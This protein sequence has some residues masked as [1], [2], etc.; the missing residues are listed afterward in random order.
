MKKIIKIN[1]KFK[2]Y[3]LIVEKNSAIK[4][5]I[6]EVEKNNK[7]IIII[8]S[9]LTN[10]IQKLKSINN[11]NLIVISASE[12][13]KSFE[14]YSK[15][16]LKILKLKID[17]SSKI[18]AVGGGTIGDLSGFVAS[19]L[20]RGVKFILFPT[21]L[22]SQVDS[23]IGGKNGINTIHGKNLV[24]TFFQPDKVIIDIS[25]LST[26]PKR[27]L[28]SGY[29]EI[30]KHA[31]IKDSKFFNWLNKNYKKILDLEN[32]YIS[33]AIVK[34][35]KIKSFFVQKDENE[36]LRNSD[37]RAMLNFGHTFGHALET[38]NSY[39]NKL[40]HGEAIA[41]G[42]SFASKIS[43][44]IGTLSNQ[45]L[46]N[47]LSHLKK[48]NLPIYDDRIKKNEIYNL[49][50]VDKKNTSNKISLIILRKIGKAYFNKK[51]F[52]EDIKKILN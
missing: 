6:N 29:A 50:L 15:I 28:R 51:M 2:N 7:N 49:M 21:T 8:D 22:L 9:K 42:M 25:F 39:S 52:K 18:I 19:T 10:L 35:I 46:D 47:I 1:S 23:S 27:E 11:V 5:I 16:C 31:L 12:K 40:T 33:K 3:S 4:H 30:L 48:V 32:D 37:S 20:L 45:E 13:I 44:K 41:I 17:R 24:G 34:S 26:L 36:K 14:N 43:N 38:M